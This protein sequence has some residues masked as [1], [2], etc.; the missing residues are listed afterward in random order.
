[1]PRGSLTTAPP[2]SWW[3][4]R[5][6]GP[7][8][9]VSKRPRPPPAAADEEAGTGRRQPIEKGLRHVVEI[10]IVSP[11]CD[12]CHRAGARPGCGMGPV[13]RGRR[14]A[15]GGGAHGRPQGGRAR[16]DHRG[17]GG[18]GAG[19]GGAQRRAG[20]RAHR[21]RLRGLRRAPEAEGDR[22][23]GAGPGGGEGAGHGRSR[24]GAAAPFPVPLRPVV[25]RA[26]VDRQGAP[27][28]A[29][30]AAG[31]PPIRPGGGGQLQ[32]GQRPAAA[33][34]LHLRPAAGVA[35]DRQPR[36][37]AAGRP[38]SRSAAA[39]RRAAGHGQG[40]S[41]GDREQPGPGAHV[42]ARQPPAAAGGGRRARP[43]VHRSRAAAGGHPW[44]QRGDLPVRRVRH[45]AAARVREQRRSGSDGRDD[46]P[47]QGLP[48]RLRPAL[49]RH[50][51]LQRVGEDDGGVPALR[52]HHPI[53]RHRRGAAP[54]GPAR[55]PVRRSG[56]GALFAMAH[57][58]GG[59]L[60]HNFND[61]GV[62]MGQLLKK[63][64]VTY[65]LTFQ[66]DEVKHDGSYHKL[67]VEL[68]GQA[69]KGAQVFFRPGYYVPKPYSQQ[70]QKEKIL[71]AADQVVGGSD[72]G[73]VRTALLVAP[74]R[75]AASA[76]P[77]ASPTGTAPGSAGGAAA[78]AGNAGNAGGTGSRTASDKAYVPVLIEADGPTLLEGSV[79]AALPAEIYAYAIDSAGAIQDF[80]SQ[81]LRLDLAKAAPAL[82][83]GGLKF[84]GHL[85]LPPGEY[86]VRVLVRNG[87]TGA[88]G[89]RSQPLVVPAFGEPAAVLL[90]PFFPEAPGRWVMVKEAPRQKQEAPPYP[91]VI[92]ERAYIPASLPVVPA[93]QEVAM[94]LVGYHLPAGAFHGRARLLAADGRGP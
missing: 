61:L 50:A 81:S 39:D 68:K 23:R 87:A 13:V 56:E 64:S 41:C 4:R 37:G 88:Y 25:L 2:G 86:N 8:V 78:D 30:D 17:G 71:A 94:A 84:F 38:Q 70:T 93:G 54:D 22:L 52:L 19:A 18:A 80:F 29:R 14:R 76:S 79:G 44:P 83:R 85:D 49:R 57:D 65:V 62:A 77:A 36:P 47:G 1:M 9:R 60:Y 43:V 12:P 92:Q 67:R 40:G 26:G 73:A 11:A 90:Q 3:R 55:P 51:Q 27:D 72:S 58:T 16:R 20:A 66:P 34:R 48:H 74:F 91:F 46:D 10:V 69:G 31:S 59:E 21:R 5:G 45:L 32:L 42:G 63:T 24:A 6:R 82:R 89:L 35:G 15:M 28:G 53:D 75:Q 33:A 7:G